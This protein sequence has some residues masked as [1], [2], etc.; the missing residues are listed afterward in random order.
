[1][2]CGFIACEL[3]LDCFCA[4]WLFLLLAVGGLLFESDSNFF[5]AL[6]LFALLSVMSFFT[7][8]TGLSSDSSTSGLRTNL[9]PTCIFSSVADKGSAS[10]ASLGRYKKMIS[11]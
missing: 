4:V 2:N 5:D 11:L 1:M 7:S 3:W 9:Y 8:M 6:L 10:I